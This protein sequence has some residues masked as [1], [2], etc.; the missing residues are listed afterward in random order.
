MSPIGARFFAWTLLQVLGYF[1]S[2]CATYTPPLPQ[3]VLTGTDGQGTM[4]QRTMRLSPPA[5]LVRY[6]SVGSNKAL[7]EATALKWK[8]KVLCLETGGQTGL[9]FKTNNW[10]YGFYTPQGRSLNLLTTIDSV[11]I[12]RIDALSR[13]RDKLISKGWNREVSALVSRITAPQSDLLIFPRAVGDANAFYTNTLLEYVNQQ[14]MVFGIFQGVKNGP[15]FDSSTDLDVVAHETSHKMQLSDNPNDFGRIP[16]NGGYLEGTADLGSYYYQ[17]ST[18][19]L[20][21]NKVELTAGNLE[22]DSF[23][24]QMGEM[25][26]AAL[27]FQTGLR[28]LNDNISLT[29]NTLKGKMDSNGYRGS[30]QEIHEIGRVLSGVMYDVHN[31]IVQQAWNSLGVI[32][33]YVQRINQYGETLYRVTQAFMEADYGARILKKSASLSDYLSKVYELLPITLTSVN[34][35]RNAI[36]AVLNYFDSR[37][38]AS[39]VR[40]KPGG[41][42]GADE[43]PGNVFLVAQ[44]VSNPQGGENFIQHCE[45]FMCGFVKG[46]DISPDPVFHGVNTGTQTLQNRN[47]PRYYFDYTKGMPRQLRV[48]YANPQVEALVKARTLTLSSKSWPDYIGNET[49]SPANN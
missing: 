42:P 40:A 26:G 10:L 18:I 24:N 22:A 1:A 7:F 2:A 4:D 37:A 39:N 21:Q 29:P 36:T 45:G 15:W 6:V 5:E 17:L 33:D 38:K 48:V 49:Y 34:F 16:I 23:T 32:S 14:A 25:F 28:N 11:E 19:K 31:F 13:L 27:K 44:S 35:S 9:N 12:Q 8:D 30:G 47:L 20:C 41:Q 43:M 3:L 46:K